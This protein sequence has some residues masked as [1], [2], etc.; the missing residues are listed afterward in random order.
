MHAWVEWVV[1]KSVGPQ[2]IVFS[3]ESHGRYRGDKYYVGQ[4]N[5]PQTAAASTDRQM[6]LG[7]GYGDWN[8]SWVIR[9]NCS[10]CQRV[11]SASKPMISGAAAV[12]GM[13]NR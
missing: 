11:S 10:F 13:G 12:R 7:N 5:H 8:L 3:L 6:E 4:L 9:K 2:K 1:L